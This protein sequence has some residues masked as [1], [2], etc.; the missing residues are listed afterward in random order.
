MFVRSKYPKKSW[1]NCEKKTTGGGKLTCVPLYIGKPT[2]ANM[3]TLPQSLPINV[4][5]EPGAFFSTVP[6][7][8]WYSPAPSH[9]KASIWSSVAGHCTATWRCASCWLLKII[10]DWCLQA[11]GI[12]VSSTPTYKQ[13]CSFRP[14][15]LLQTVV[16]RFEMSQK[17]SICV[18]LQTLPAI[19]ESLRCNRWIHEI[20]GSLPAINDSRMR[21]Q[22]WIEDAF[23]LQKCVLLITAQQ[24]VLLFSKLN[25]MLYRYLDPEKFFQDNENK[26]LPLWP[27]RHFG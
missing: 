8:A 23:W 6:V 16:Y 26:Q 15:G 2:A 14:P 22:N 24:S 25:K 21:F 17:N 1:F 13:C 18:C 3:S 10:S 7:P 19:N 27:Q 12:V 4:I 20:D 9:T 5:A 11:P